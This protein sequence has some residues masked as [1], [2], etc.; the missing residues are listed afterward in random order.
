MYVGGLYTKRI[1]KGAAIGG[2]LVGFLVSLFWLVFV[3]RSEASALLICNAIFGRPHLFG[4]TRTGFILWA[5]V[6]AL[7]VALPLSTLVT[8]VL[9]YITRPFSSEH[10]KGCFGK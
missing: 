4:D 7:V 3:H 8:I 2:A 5:E 1:T 10:I 6:D 9:S